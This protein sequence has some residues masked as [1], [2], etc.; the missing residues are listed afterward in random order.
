[1]SEIGLYDAMST[2]R[3]VRRLKPDPIP[4][5]VLF[6]V[7][8]AASWA[9]TGG[10]A[11]P[12]RVLVVREPA[13]KKRLGELYR[14][15]WYAYVEH[16]LTLIEDAP[17]K[18]KLS[19]RKMLD[20]GSYLADH[21]AEIPVLLVFC[22]NPRNMAITD[23][24]LD[25]ISVVGGA[26]IYPS[27]ENALLACRAEGLGCVLTTLLCQDEDEIRRLLEIPEP[28]ATAAAIPIGYPVLRGHGPIRR[29]PVEEL[30]FAETWGRAWIPADSDEKD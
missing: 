11:Q 16:H 8:E 15:S 29:R 26:S 14:K 25:R 5:E 23:A 19:S 28:W 9:P 21:F 10:N 20:S 12:W 18:V 27:V 13:T 22:F 3:A 7:L 2:L 1:M 30:A 6:R 4:D 24:R 17:E